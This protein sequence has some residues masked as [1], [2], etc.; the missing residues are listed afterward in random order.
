MEISSLSISRDLTTLDLVLTNASD[1]SILR[2]WTNKTYKN[3]GKLIDLSPKLIGGTTQEISIT[4]DDIDEDYFDGIYFIEAEDSTESATEFV[5]HL[6]RYE[7]CVLDKMKNLKICDSCNDRVEN[8]IINTQML[9]NSLEKAIANRF[10]D[11]M[12]Y[13]TTGLDKLCSDDCKTCGQYG[14]VIDANSEI[15]NYNPITV[16]IDGGEI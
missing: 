3:F 2:F 11:E 16:K 7:E 15:G 8:N 9:L 4:L 1:V 12:I 6:R 14:N 10:V 13:L 5:A